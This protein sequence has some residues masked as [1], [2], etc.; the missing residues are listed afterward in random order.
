MNNG[1]KWGL[2]RD[3]T[4]IHCVSSDILSTVLF[5]L[6][7]FGSMGGAHPRGMR[8]RALRVLTGFIVF[9][10]VKKTKWFS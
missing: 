8:Q 3:A 9:L 5:I 4:G 10:S 6:L 7:N 1:K 2:V